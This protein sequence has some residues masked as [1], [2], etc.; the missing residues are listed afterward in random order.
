MESVTDD[1]IKDAIENKYNVK[2][3]Y[4]DGDRKTS[5]GPTQRYVQIYVL[6]DTLA[7]NPAIRAYQIGGQSKSGERNWKLFRLDRIVKMEPTKIRWNN[8]IDN[9]VDSIPEYNRSGDKSMTN[10]RAMVKVPQ[11]QGGAVGKETDRSRPLTPDERKDMLAKDP[12]AFKL[13]K[14]TPITPV[15]SIPKPAPIEK[16]AEKS[17]YAATGSAKPE[18]KPETPEIKPIDTSKTTAPI[19]ANKPNEKNKENG[20]TNASRPK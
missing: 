6:G 9:M 18:L 16:G 11:K 10:I 17:S 12:N 15:P 13:K 19:E 8:S 7:N 3:W 1:Q 20:S 4:D 14:P 5:S 2:L